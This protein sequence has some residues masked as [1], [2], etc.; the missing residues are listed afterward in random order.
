[1][2]C[3]PV[4]ICAIRIVT[5]G[6]QQ[7]DAEVAQPPDDHWTSHRLGE[8]QLSVPVR[9]RLARSRTAQLMRPRGD[10]AR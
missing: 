7:A 4:S 5:D 10:D 9:E 1:L 6:E 2:R 3:S 8:S